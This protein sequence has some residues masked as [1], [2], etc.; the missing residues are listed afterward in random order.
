MRSLTVVQV[1]P[2][3][4]SGG[5]E[6]GTLELGAYLSKMGHR[7]IVISAGGRMVSKLESEGS[8]HINWPIGKKSLFTLSLVNR[9]KH[10]LET[11][12]VDVLH[13]RSRFPAWIAYMAWSMMQADKRP[14]LVS[15]VHGPYS[16]SKY[17]AVMTK[18]QR[19]IV[20]S[21]MIREYAIKNYDAKPENLRL[22]YRGVD[23]STY[24][25]NY[26]ASEQ[27]RQNW[28]NQHPNT[29]GKKL[30]TLP[31]RVTR[32]KGQEDFIQ[33]L[34]FVKQQRNDVHALIVGEVKKGKSKYFSKLKA[35]AS[36]LGIAD[37]IT[38][39]D[40]RDDIK[41]IMSISSLVYSLSTE[42]EAFGRTTI[43]ALTLGVPVIGYNHG[44]VSEQLAAMLPE[45]AVEVGNYT[46]AGVLTL[47]WLNSAP[48]VAA[49]KLFTLDNMLSSTLKV[50]RELASS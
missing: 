25:H 43:E 44:G 18:G 49:N 19:V 50:Y 39:T 14:A 12:K 31:A 40:H 2:S 21:N 22:I 20:I 1:L 17:S 45:G 8:E 23:T 36:S 10:F 7:S 3:L 29:K 15:T 33:L 37:M 6:R 32:W 9:L 47:S 46:E 16:V 35:L 13:V 11:E 30:L 28:F 41:E 42:P 38:F 34:S 48:T 4:S 5:V 27:W 26:Q 24:H